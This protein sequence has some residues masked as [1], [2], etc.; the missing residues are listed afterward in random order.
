MRTGV[1]VVL[2]NVFVKAIWDDSVGDVELVARN[3]RAGFSG[4]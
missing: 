3:G 1:V 2:L 4:V